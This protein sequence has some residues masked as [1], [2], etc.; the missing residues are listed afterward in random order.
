[1]RCNANKGD[2][3]FSVVALGDTPRLYV[4][5]SKL[6]QRPFTL[7]T[8]NYIYVTDIFNTFRCFQGNNYS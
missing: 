8:P 6:F 1:L 7:Y 4:N 2:C 5:I 3:D